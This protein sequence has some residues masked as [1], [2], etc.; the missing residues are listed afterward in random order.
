VKIFGKTRVAE[1]TAGF[2]SNAKAVWDVV[3]NNNDYSW[4][5]DIERVEIY[6][7]W[8]VSK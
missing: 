3:T 8:R 1:I 7:D 4:R 6:N 5:S 2:N